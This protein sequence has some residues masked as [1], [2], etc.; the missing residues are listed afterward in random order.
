MAKHGD[1]KN[2]VELFSEHSGMMQE[3]MESLVNIAQGI[4]L[5]IQNKKK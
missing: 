4:G 2:F 3:S 5:L 1:P